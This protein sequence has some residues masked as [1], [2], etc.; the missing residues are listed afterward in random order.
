MSPSLGRL[1]VNR[2]LMAYTA[3]AMYGGAAFDAALEGVLPGDPSFAVVPALVAAAVAVVLVLG[4][5]RL[6]RWGLAPLGAIGV[7]LIAC[8]LAATTGAGDG[9]MLYMWPVLWTTFFFGRRGA[10]S[11]VA[12]VGVAH[13]ITLL[14]LPGSSSYPGRWVDVMVS[15]S[16]VAAVALTLVRHNDLLLSRLAGEA[17][18]DALTGLLN[19]RGFRERAALELARAR[20]EAQPVAVA[21]FD[22]DHFKRVNDRWGHEVGDRVLARTCMLL[23]A[24]T[25]DIDVLARFG[26]EEFVALLPGCDSADAE[27]FTER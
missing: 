18:T 16:V 15:V 22:V 24:Q 17:R 14:V 2:A 5:P 26:G 23:A 25:R 9:A 10:V 8:S 3:A 1:R 12:C 20:R 11:I 21:T 4:G 19:R 27:A 6:P 13:A 7:V